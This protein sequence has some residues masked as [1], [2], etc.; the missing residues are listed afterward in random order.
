[1]YLVAIL[2]FISI[3]A[4]VSFPQEPIEFLGLNNEKITS[5]SIYSGVIAVG[6]DRNGV[7]WQ[8]EHSLTDTSWIHIE[9][10]SQSVYTVYAHKSGP[11]GWAISAGVAPD[12]GD[13]TFIYC[14]FMGGDFI[15]NSV[16]ITDSLTDKVSELDG[17]PDPTIC[18]E[19]YAAGGRALYRREFTSSSWTPVYTASI[20]GYFQTIKV[21]EQYSGVV[22]AGG[23]EGFAGFLLIKSTD[24]GEN[25]VDI[26]PPGTVYS[27]DF[28]GESAETIFTAVSEK[29][30]K[31]SDGGS[32]WEA[33][34]DGAGSYHLT[35]VIYDP[36]SKRVF[37]AGGDR[38]SNP[39]ATILFS[40]DDGENWQLFSLE[41]NG[42]IVDLEFGNGWTYFVTP[43]DGVFRFQDLIVAVD[44]EIRPLP[45][46]EFQ[47]RQNYPNPFNASTMIEYSIPEATR[48]VLTIYNSLGQEIAKLLNQ[49]QPAGSYV[50][51]WDASNV[52]SGVYFY[53]LRASGR[54]L[55]RKT[56]VLK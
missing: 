18:G 42:P 10:D 43:D 2:L 32:S 28:A 56:L 29:I 38:L 41:I 20:E 16:G 27:L 48:V 54:T 13:S 5:L 36:Q 17:F 51:R 12:K 22:L 15:P 34:F 30:Y 50:T 4:K 8:S 9:L 55:V 3:T 19:T 45:P 11:L 21:N 47:L 39:R 7:F 33:V 37:V 1:M 35:E 49:D 14:S 40:D 6:T 44:E 24:Y 46:T 53:E 31:S 23:A 25:W 26:S 52:N